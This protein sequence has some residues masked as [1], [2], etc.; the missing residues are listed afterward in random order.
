MSNLA[1]AQAAW[2]ALPEED[3]GDGSPATKAIYI[4]GWL[5]GAHAALDRQLVKVKAMQLNEV[6]S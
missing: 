5:D 6:T 4:V 2:D 1:T 3:R